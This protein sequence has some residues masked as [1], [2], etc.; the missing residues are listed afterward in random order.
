M[1]Y[2]AIQTHYYNCDDD[3]A[4]RWSLF[5]ECLKW[6]YIDLGTGRTGSMFALLHVYLNLKV[7]I[8]YW[9]SMQHDEVSHI[10]PILLFKY[11]IR[12][13]NDD[14]SVLLY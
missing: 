11:I 3:G 2:F 6:S 14:G 8:N 4:L 10:H 9:C 7:F 12:C 5:V 1:R 13:N